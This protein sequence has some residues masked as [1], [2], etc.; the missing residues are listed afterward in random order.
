MTF[1]ATAPKMEPELPTSGQLVSWDDW[2]FI[3]FLLLAAESILKGININV[4]SL[5]PFVLNALSPDKMILVW[6]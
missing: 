3:T 4:P 6:Q 1:L 2:V 5:N